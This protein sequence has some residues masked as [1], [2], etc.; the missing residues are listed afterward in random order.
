MKAFYGRWKTDKKTGVL[1][2]KW[3]RRKVKKVDK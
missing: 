3:K 1:V 2:W